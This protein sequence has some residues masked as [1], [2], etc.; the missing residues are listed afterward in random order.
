MWTWDPAKNSA[1]KA[2]HGVSFE[3]A[4]RVLLD[5]LRATRIDTFPAE[6]RWQTIGRP[7]ADSQTVLIVIHTDHG[8]GGR[9]ISARKAMRNERLAYEQGFF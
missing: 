3:T 6:Q 4:E 1:N 5:P 8:D 9:I 2:K 7:T